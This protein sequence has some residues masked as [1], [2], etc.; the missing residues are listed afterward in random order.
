MRKLVALVLP[1]VVLGSSGVAQ[2]EKL[3]SPPF[4]THI[5]TSA[6]C[7][8]RNTGTTSVTISA[9]LFGN[10]ALVIDTD[11]CNGNNGVLGPGQTCVII[12]TDLPDDSFVA[13]S[14]TAGTVGKLR[15]TLEIRETIDAVLRVIAAE[16]LR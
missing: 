11:T 5:L 3:V 10:N 7:Y 2:A 4:G 15:G 12:D 6:A 14:V 9:S 16:D 1:A 13:C 8:I